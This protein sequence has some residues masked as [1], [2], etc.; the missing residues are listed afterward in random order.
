MGVRNETIYDCD[1]CA[2]EEKARAGMKN[3]SFL[4]ITASP[5]SMAAKSVALCPSCADVLDAALKPVSK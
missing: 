2:T 4:T 5:L 1:R 3:W